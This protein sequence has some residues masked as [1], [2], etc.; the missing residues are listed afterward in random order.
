MPDLA[1]VKDNADQSNGLQVIV[2]QLRKMMVV[3]PSLVLDMAKVSA[4]PFSGLQVI[5]AALLKS[6]KLLPHPWKQ[7]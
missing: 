6:V 1:M 4:D 7:S 5:P 3:L 2:A